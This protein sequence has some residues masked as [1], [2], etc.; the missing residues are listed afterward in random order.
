M[1]WP[2]P[3]E[4]NEAIQ[5][6]R[7][8][9]ADAE[10]QAGQPVLTPLGLPRPITGAFASVYQLACPNG[11]TYAVRCFLREFGDNQ[12]RYAAI[13]AH[14]AQARLPYMVNFTYLANGIRVNRQW[15]PILKMEWVEGESLQAYV[16]RN[17][18]NT[19]ALLGLAEQW[20]QMARM[21]REA[22]IG[23][24][25]LQHGNV[26]VCNGQLRLIDYDGMYVPALTGRHS[27]ELGHRNYQHPQ[28]SEVDFDPAVDHFSTWVVYTSLVALSVDPQLW[29]TFQGGDECLIFR[30]EDF[31]RPGTSPL[32]QTLAASA[33]ARMRALAVVFQSLTVLPP[34]QV[35]PIDGEVMLPLPSGRAGWIQDHLPATPPPAT[36]LPPEGAR[37]QEAAVARPAEPAWLHDFLGPQQRQPA[38]FGSD[39]TRQ[40]VALFLSVVFSAAAWLAV[41]LAGLS[42][43]APALVTLAAVVGSLSMVADGYRRD[44]TVLA[45]RAAR[46]DLKQVNTRM[47]GVTVRLAQQER[48]RSQIERVYQRQRARFEGGQQHDLIVEK[49][50]L[51]RNERALQQALAGVQYQRDRQ[52]R[53]EAE[54]VAQLETRHK[55]HL[56]TLDQRIVALRQTE[57]FELEKT[58]RQRQTQFV[59]SYLKRQTI[60]AAIITGIGPAVKQSLRQQGIVRAT[61]IDAARLAQVQGVGDARATALLEWRR[62]IEAL[63]RQTAPQDLSKIEETLIR[64]RFYQR[65]FSIE[66]ERGR[67]QRKLQ[68]AIEETHARFAF[69][70]Q[71]ADQQQVKVRER[72]DRKR[73]ELRKRHRER[74]ARLQAELADLDH[75][76]AAEQASVQQEAHAVQQELA[77][78]TAQRA[79]AELRLRQYEGID[80]SSYVKRVIWVYQP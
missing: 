4:Y 74:R 79:V 11:R 37:A 15:V 17:L 76:V 53:L 29:K 69:T 73:E 19:P 7:T 70:Q 67:E 1:G 62:R 18:H 12:D 38:S 63:A 31:E 60:E 16:E 28:R 35:P 13:S 9:F 5:N 6:P 57:T 36:L 72:F 41:D 2:T 23:H 66:Q 75:Q 58:L 59:L 21:L 32:F 56:T 45:Q 43:M 14:L 54:A 34:Y 55:A 25:D 3:Q 50:A 30:R 49:A 46:R 52:R 48:G 68:K 8:A 22:S 33:D 24:G 64:G 47:R 80:F 42:L 65:R 71:S 40:R 20:V 10:L 78:L 44:P 61:D 27:H 39:L 26:M 51:E 77:Q